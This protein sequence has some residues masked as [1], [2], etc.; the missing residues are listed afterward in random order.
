METQRRAFTLIELLCV[1]AIIALLVMLLVP[2]LS[3]SRYASSELISRSQMH[4]FD[5]LGQVYLSDHNGYFPAEPGE[6]LY[7]NASDS[8]AHPI[9]CR[10]HDAEMVPGSEIMNAKPEF[11][12][13]MWDY[14]A[15]ESFGLCPIFRDIA[16]KRGCENPKHNPDISIRPQFNYSINGYLGSRREG[17]VLRKSEVRDPAVVFFFAEENSWTVRPDHPKYPAQWLSAPLSTTVLDDTVLLIT[18]TPDARD[19]FATHHRPPEGDLNRG[20]GPVLFV[21]GHGDDIW[22]EQQLRQKMHGYDGPRRTSSSRRSSMEWHS[23]GNLYY[24]WA[25]KSPPPGG[26]DGQ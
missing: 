21:D 5:I 8:P 26:W 15:G 11:R 20:S 19:C 6:W 2:T 17:G 14:M 3:R 23:A 9:G 10:W 1:I 12:G 25:A 4:S 18:P 7:T 13:I 16:L 22:A 24:A